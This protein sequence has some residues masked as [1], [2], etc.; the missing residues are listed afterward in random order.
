MNQYLLD[1]YRVRQRRRRFPCDSDGV[2]TNTPLHD[3]SGN[4]TQIDGARFF[5]PPLIML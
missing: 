4:L 3:P 2:L 1:P 5:R